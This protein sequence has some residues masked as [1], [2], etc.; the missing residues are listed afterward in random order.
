MQNNMQIEE[1]TITFDIGFGDDV[2]TNPINIE[3]TK[4]IGKFLRDSEITLEFS[5]EALRKLLHE[6][7]NYLTGNTSGPAIVIKSKIRIGDEELNCEI[8]S[9]V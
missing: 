8:V 7:A 1:N 5:P 2:Q 9:V 6:A 3:Q 4:D